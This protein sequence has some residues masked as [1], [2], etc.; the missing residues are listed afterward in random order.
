MQ[1]QIGGNNNR[2]YKKKSKPEIKYNKVISNDNNNYSIDS[3]R[4]I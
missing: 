2:Q 4:E 1:K 3:I